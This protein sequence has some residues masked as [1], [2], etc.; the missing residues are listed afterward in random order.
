M[1]YLHC[2]DHSVDDFEVFAEESFKSPFSQFLYQKVILKVKKLHNCFCQVRM[3]LR[4]CWKKKHDSF[5][6]KMLSKIKSAFHFSLQRRCA[7]KFWK[8]QETYASKSE[9]SRNLFLRRDKNPFFNQ[10]SLFV[11]AFIIG[12]YQARKWSF[13]KIYKFPFWKNIHEYLWLLVLIIP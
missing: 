4:Y 2:P 3:T 7:V 8:V 13:V 1:I 5:N 6:N 10:S 9:R 11:S 12:I